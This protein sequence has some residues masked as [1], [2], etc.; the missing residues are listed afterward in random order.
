MKILFTLVAV[1]V[2]NDSYLFS[3]KSL[4]TELL[5][6]TEADILLSTNNEE[7]FSDIIDDR[8]IIRNNVP[9][10]SILSYHGGAEFNYNL[11]YI[12]FKDLPEGYD[13]VLYVDCDIKNIFWSQQST[14]KLSE[15]ISS[16][17]FIGVRLG[18]VLSA[19]IKQ[20]KETG[21]CLFRHKII[22]YGVL[23]WPDNHPLLESCIPSEH[24]LVFKYNK[25][26]LTKFV[27]K[28]EELNYIMQENKG[29]GGCW[30]DGFE[31]GLSLKH[32]GYDNMLDLSHG[33][34]ELDFGFIF[35]GNKL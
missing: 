13:V 21:T 9:D 1:L 12:A 2:Q 11:K 30:G 22:S 33:L 35:N 4:I 18:A 8:F 3:A 23:E 25:E 10:D 27:E 15:L 6:N 31:I 20:Y 17:D 26:K 28:W 24:F 19:E 5:Q 16:F 14:D 32:A 29:E 7:F 34:V